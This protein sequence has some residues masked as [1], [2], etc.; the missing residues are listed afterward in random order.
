[1]STFEIPEPGGVTSPG[2]SGIVDNSESLSLR[3]DL[4]RFRNEYSKPVQFRCVDYVYCEVL[5]IVV[6][7]MIRVE[8]S[9]VLAGHLL[10]CHVIDSI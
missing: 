5:H 4:K 9:T 3:D 8:Q 6:V 7:C 2:V 10:L 1:M